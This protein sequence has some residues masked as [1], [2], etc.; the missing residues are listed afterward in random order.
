MPPSRA[1]SLR[2]DV[3]PRPQEPA[4]QPYLRATE[5]WTLDVALE[6]EV[7]GE[8]VSRPAARK[9]YWTP[10]QMLAHLTVN[11]ASVTAGDLFASGTVSGA[12]ANTEGSLAELWR[13]ER[14]LADGAEVVL[15]G[16][17]GDVALGEVRGRVLP[18]LASPA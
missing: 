13:G 16:S 7:D 14:W 15:R 17:A 4:P 3:A 5:P 9:L 2:L 6:I 11:G 10:A 1:L 8:V 18:A 12:E